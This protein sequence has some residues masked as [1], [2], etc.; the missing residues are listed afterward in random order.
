MKHAYF[1]GIGPDV[2][3]DAAY[4]GRDGP[5]R[6]GMHLLYSQGVLNRYR[7]NGAGGVTACGRDSFDIGLDAGAAAGIAACYCQDSWVLHIRNV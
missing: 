1:D 7:R 2:G 4:L 5:G 3:E 6:D